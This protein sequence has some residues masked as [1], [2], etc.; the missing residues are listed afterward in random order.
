MIRHHGF[1]GLSNQVI[2][3]PH[4]LTYHRYTCLFIQ[5]RIFEFLTIMTQIVL[6]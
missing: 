1:L 5:F 6:L 2:P 3:R 4:D